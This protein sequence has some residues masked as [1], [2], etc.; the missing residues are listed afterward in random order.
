MKQKHLILIL[1][2]VLFSVTSNS[3]AEKFHGEFCWQVFSE[4]G[5]STGAIN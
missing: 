1:C 2:F 3:F 4:Y 5:D